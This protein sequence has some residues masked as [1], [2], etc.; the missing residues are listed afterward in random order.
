VRKDDQKENLIFGASTGCSIT[1]NI[2]VKVS[3]LGTRS[4]ADTGIDFDGV[5]VGTSFFW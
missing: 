1:R 5:I 2:G 4:Q 3:Y